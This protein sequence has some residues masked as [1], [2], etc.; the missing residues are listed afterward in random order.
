MTHSIVLDYYF[1]F[2]V[3]L[4]VCVCVQYFYMYCQFIN[5]NNFFLLLFLLRYI[6]RTVDPFNEIFKI[7]L[8]NLF[9]V[10]WYLWVTREVKKGSWKLYGWK[11][12]FL[13]YISFSLDFG[14]HWTLFIHISSVIIEKPFFAWIKA[15]TFQSYF[16][17]NFL[18]LKR[19]LVKWIQ[20]EGIQQVNDS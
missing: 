17:S 15:S 20:N 2:C 8:F 11:W 3:L 6:H 10:L 18:G 16:N 9:I 19:N 1:P 5:T 4:C 14:T 13:K 12:F 7:F